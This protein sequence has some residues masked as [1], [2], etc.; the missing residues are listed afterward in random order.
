MVDL[1]FALI[2]CGHISTKHAKVLTTLDNCALIG[3]YDIDPKKYD[4]ITRITNDNHFKRYQNYD[5]VLNDSS[6]NTVDICTPSG[7]HYELAVKAAGAG[8]NIVIE[9]PIALTLEDSN[10]MIEICD[11]NNVKLFVVK[12]YRYHKPIQKLKEA[13]DDGRFGK[14]V[15]GNVNVY[16]SRK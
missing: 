15:S 16:W 14:I 11:K 7:T 13:I 6:V 3:A 9:K 8:K 12:Q 5:E 10:S 1:N 2:G 4:D